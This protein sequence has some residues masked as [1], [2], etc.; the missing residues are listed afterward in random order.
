LLELA[1][2]G[3]ILLNEV[4]EL[5]LSLQAKLL[6]FLDTRSFLRVGGQ[7]HVHV[8]ARL[9]A[10][11]H[12]NLMREVERGRFLG[13]LYYRLSVLPIRV[14]PLRER[15]QDLPIL[16]KDLILR[17]AA[18]M[19]LTETPAVDFA[20]I[21]SLNDYE[22]PG[23]V[24]ELKNVLERSLILWEGGP[25]QLQLPRAECEAG[26]WSYTV[27]Y[28]PNQTFH[29]IVNEVATALCSHALS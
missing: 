6:G 24:R 7:K 13:A 4:G 3:T 16:A 15:R 14:P 26:E 1:E 9:I 5:D 17:L 27:R 11:S 12:R 23:N 22:W 21:R 8:N 20:V 25:F 10:A 2:G 18:E 29:E 19:Q 28:G